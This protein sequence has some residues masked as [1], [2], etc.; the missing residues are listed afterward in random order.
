L[1]LLTTAVKGSRDRDQFQNA[2]MSSA[3]WRSVRDRQSEISLLDFQGVPKNFI[4][5]LFKF[6]FSSQ[7]QCL[8][9]D[10]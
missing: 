7:R 4:C 5:Y 3:D 2:V 9:M 6:A 8:A 10:Q 1:I